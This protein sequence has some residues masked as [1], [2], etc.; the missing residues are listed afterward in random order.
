MSYDLMVFDPA[1]APRDRARF[2]AWYGE[3]TAWGEGHS[4]DD[5]SIT[6]DGLRRWYRDMLATFP[7]MNGPDAADRPDDS[8]V[9]DDLHLTDY[10]IA[11]HAI[12]CA[13]S[14]SVGE[15]ALA[16]VPQLAAKHEV[17]FFDVSADAGQIRFP[18]GLIL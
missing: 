17:G 9:W 1:V 3:L 10:S 7:A 4:Y 8:P 2:M 12:Y 11:R 6:T 13:F 14:W 5:A 15:E 18:D 16:A